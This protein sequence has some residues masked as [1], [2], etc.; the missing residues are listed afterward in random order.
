MPRSPSSKTS[1]KSASYRGHARTEPQDA[2]DILADD[3]KRVLGL[4]DEFAQMKEDNDPDDEARQLLVE[5]TCAELTI[6]AQVEEELFYPALREAT[7]ALDLLDEAEVEHASARQ[8]ITE[9]AA[10]QPED[11]LYDAK[12]TVLGEY[13]RHH[14]QEEEKQIFPKA[15]KA[16]LDLEGLGDDIRQRKLE[17]RDELGIAPQEPVEDEDEEPAAGKKAGRRMH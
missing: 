16:E 15:K 11:D 12:F 7:D 17:L 5:S 14:I 3:H 9:L 4:F 2:L 10:M 8:L 6:H 1:S 13:V